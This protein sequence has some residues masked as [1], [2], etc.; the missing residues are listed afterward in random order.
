MN[1]TKFINPLL[2][3]I[4]IIL[5]CSCT[6]KQN[7]QDIIVSEDG[8][9]VIPFNS[10]QVKMVNVKDKAGLKQGLWYEFDSISSL[11][12][13]EYNYINDT[14]EGY[15]LEYKTGS[16]DTLLYGHYKKGQK[17]GNWI[18]WQMESDKIEKVENYSY[19][20]LIK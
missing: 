5:L 12:K 6:N 10:D 2:F 19:G 8:S 16:F 4:F 15:Y 1:P 20:E 11:I 7:N 14:L 17:N 3:F 18:Y 9:V 13:I